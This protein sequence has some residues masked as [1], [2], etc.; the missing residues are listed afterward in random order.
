MSSSNESSI[1]TKQQRRRYILNLLQQAASKAVEVADP[2]WQNSSLPTVPAERVVRHLYNPQTQTWSTDETIVKMEE[3]PFTNGAMRFCYRMKKRAQPPAS[4]TNHCFHKMGWKTAPNY[5]AKCYQKDDEVDTS[6]EAKAAVMNDIVLQYEAQEWATRFN[7]ADPPSKIHFIRAYVIEFV[8]RPGRPRFAVERFIAGKD[9]YG[10][11]FVKHNT[12][13]GFVDPELRRVTPQVFSAHS[14]YASEGTR[15]V[16]DIQGVGNLYTDPQVLSS[17]YRFG[18]G[19]LGPRG[20]ALFFKSFRNCGTSDSLGIPIF[21]LSKNELKHQ[22]KYDEDEDTVSDEGGKSHDD[23]M[24]LLSHEDTLDNFQRLDQNRLRRSKWLNVGVPAGIGHLSDDDCG[25]SDQADTQVR[26]NISSP[27]K[28][29]APIA[30]TRALLSKSFRRSIRNNRN[31][32]AHIRRTVSD[33]DE[34]AAC[35]YRARHNLSF[36]LR[37]YHRNQSGEIRERH[38]RDNQF[39]KSA[40]VKHISPPMKITELTNENLGR[41]HYQ[42]AVLHGTGRFPEVVPEPTNDGGSR[43]HH[44]SF[45]VLFHL[46]HAAA[47]QNAPACLCLARVHAGLETSVS[48]LL[49]LIVPID[50]SASKDLL[51]R[52]MATPQQPSAPKAAAGCLL[53]QILLEEREQHDLEEE[54]ESTQ[55]GIGANRVPKI[56]DGQLEQVLTDTLKLFDEMEAEAKEAEQHRSTLERQTPGFEPG[57]RVEGDY[58]LEGTF[59]PATV[60]SAEEDGAVTVVYDDDGSSESLPL[61][62]VRPLIPLTATQTNSGGPLSDGVAFGEDEDCRLHYTHYELQ[63]EL[64]K[65]KEKAGDKEGASA[66]YQDAADRAMTDGKMKSATDW[67][68]R[69]AELLE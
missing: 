35:L 14:F 12:N 24:S 3:K 51:H 16:A 26:S 40:I 36:S 65:L 49:Q 10:A 31:P 7:D 21:Q 60:S 4:A 55:K 13:A 62:H 17:D 37:D 61:Q 15:L 64:A 47:L 11:G 6:E 59:Y 2:W 45:S 8:H 32:K 50:F 19:D 43:P 9:S 54:Q 52:A 53:L 28:P 25:L 22:L 41:V 34:V 66:L 42:L 63:V 44:D 30:S 38:L 1:T 46:S 48:D 23:E 67:S 39:H 18:E 68:L 29:L 27:K 33:M 5:V 58:C 20:M 56:L 57:D 69:A